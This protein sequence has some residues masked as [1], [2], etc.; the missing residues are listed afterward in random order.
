ME[1]IIHLSDSRTQENSYFF[2]VKVS[3]SEDE[4]AVVVDDPVVVPVEVPPVIEEIE[5]PTVSPQPIVPRI[6]LIN[7]V[8]EV[9]IKFN[10]TMNTDVEKLVSEQD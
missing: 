8:G 6:T 7:Q 3:Y 5:P 10:A 4:I 1:V 9:T 2:A